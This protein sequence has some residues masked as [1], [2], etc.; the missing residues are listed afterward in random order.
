MAKPSNTSKTRI[1]IGGVEVVLL[2][3]RQKG[4]LSDQTLRSAVA[5]GLASKKTTATK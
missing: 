4:K 3:E 1:K 5:K 2:P